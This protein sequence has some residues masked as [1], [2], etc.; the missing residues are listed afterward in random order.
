MKELLRQCQICGSKTGDPFK[1]ISFCGMDGE[2]LPNLFDVCC[3]AGC[4]FC[5]DDIGAGQPAFDAYYR[6]VSKYAAAD[7]G[8]SG[9][10]SAADMEKWGKVIRRITA[11]VG[12]GARVLDVGC[13]KGGLLLALREAGF[14]DV[15][16]IEPSPACRDRLSAVSIPCHA[17]LPECLAE[18][19]APFDCVVCSQVLEHVFDLREFV[20]QIRRAVGAEGAVYVEVPNMQGYRERMHAPFYY[21]DREHINHFTPA[22]LDNLF[23]SA[24]SFRP[25][26]CETSEI[27]SVPGKRTPN[28]TAVYRNGEFSPGVVYDLFGERAMRDYVSKCQRADTYPQ[29]KEAA[30]APVLLWGLGAHL[31]RLL[32]EGVFA[33]TR[34]AAIVDRDKGGHGLRVS[35]IPVISPAQALGGRYSADTVFITSVLYAE[36]IRGALASAGY[37]GRV[38]ELTGL[39][40][41][42]R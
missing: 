19:P 6:Q 12:P 14:P 8:G 16:G 36:Q 41:T 37:R 25:V 42:I 40:P 3:C 5:F 38:S 15:A 18:R 39:A 22:S 27:V 2:T 23:A 1:T 10:S 24:G 26:L 35:G 20:G 7:V 34:V 13:G 31:R 29:I 33:E 17:T 4:G 9:G 32:A 28:L 11:Q 21:F 30:G